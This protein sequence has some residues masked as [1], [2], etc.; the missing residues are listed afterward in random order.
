MNEINFSEP[1][2]YILTSTQDVNLFLAGVG[3]GKTHLLGFISGYLLWNFPE[4]FGFIAANTY[5]QLTTSTLFRTRE[6][7]EELFGWKEEIDYVVGKKPPKHFKTDSHNFDSY[8]GII[9]FRWGAVA[10]KGSLDNAKAHDGKEFGWGMLDETK[11]SREED[12]KDTILTRLRMPGIYVDNLTGQLT[13]Y[14]YAHWSDN[15]TTLFKLNCSS[16]HRN[17]TLST[18]R[19]KQAYTQAPLSGARAIET[20]DHRTIVCKPDACV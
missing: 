8:A 20:F 10:F 14:A 15:R 2:E 18:K 13:K 12:V 7:W 19:K 9:S 17:K 4:V 11:D 5:Q 1:Q 16:T 6:V 3:S